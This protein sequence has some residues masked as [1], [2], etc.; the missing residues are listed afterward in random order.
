M[1][2]QVT[3]SFAGPFISSFQG[4]SDPVVASSFAASNATLLTSISQVSEACCILLIPLLHERYGIKGVMLIAMFAWVLRFG[5]F[6]LGNPTMPGVLLFI[7]S[8]IVYGVALRL[9]QCLRRN[10]RR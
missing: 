7:L 1:S 10:F 4:S 2:L 5:L 6:G 9:L 8:C 3:N